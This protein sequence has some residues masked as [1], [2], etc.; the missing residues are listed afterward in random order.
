MAVKAGTKATINTAPETPVLPGAASTP[1]LPG[2]AAST[3]TPA[4]E[5]QAPKAPRKTRAEKEAEMT[6][7]HERAVASANAG[8]TVREF[9]TAEAVL[10]GERRLVNNIMALL[11]EIYNELG[12]IPPRF[13]AEKVGRQRREKDA[14]NVSVATLYTGGKVKV[15]YVTSTVPK[16]V[17]E[18]SGL[19]ADD[20]I[21]WSALAGNAAGLQE[22]FADAAEGTYIIGFIQ[23]ATATHPAAE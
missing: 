17:F 20:K 8:Q 22:Y 16:S 13:K 15:P 21:E 1:E 19:Q 3:G 5:A 4:P 2:A 10:S 18:A 23:P 6:A 7:F 14:D 12:L 9:T 11:G